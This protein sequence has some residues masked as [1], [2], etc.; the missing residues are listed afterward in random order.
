MLYSR[1][2]DLPRT[3]IETTNLDNR[4]QFHDINDFILCSG[5]KFYSLFFSFF[6]VPLVI[7]VIVLTCGFVRLGS[8]IS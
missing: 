3:I 4:M 5:V 8:F 2:D 6:D 7:S 1:L